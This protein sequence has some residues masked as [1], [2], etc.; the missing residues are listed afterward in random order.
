MSDAHRQAAMHFSGG[1]YVVEL[2]QKSLPDATAL[3]A[4][5]EEWGTLQQE[6][7]AQ[8]DATAAR[9]FGARVER[10]RRWRMRIRYLP[11]RPTCPYHFSVHRLGDAIW[12]TVGGEPYSLLQRSLRQR[13]PD[14]PILLTP[15]AGDFQVAYLLPA[16]LYG[17]GLYQEEPSILAKGCLELLIEA[18]AQRIGELV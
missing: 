13:F 10:A 12:V 14:H 5:M 1:N 11:D 9:N 3:E 16:E 6:A 4:E 15:L 2:P 17:V 8:G 18:I 7:D